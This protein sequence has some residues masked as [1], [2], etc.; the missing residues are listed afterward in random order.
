MHTTQP[1][2]SFLTLL[3]L[4]SFASVNAVLFTP[5]LPDIAKFFSIS[6]SAA[7][8]TITWFLIG[9]AIGQLIYGPLANRYGRKPA[10]FA[11][12]ALQII[13]SLI[14]VLS[15]ELHSY[16][17]LVLGRFL[18][19]LGSAVGLQM[20]FTL[21]TEYYTPKVANQKVSYLMLAFAITPGLGIALGGFLNTHFGWTSCFYACAV[22]G[23]LLLCLTL[24]FPQFQHILNYDALKLKHLLHG[25]RIQFK[26]SQLVRYALLMGCSASFVYVFAALGPFIAIDLFHLSSNAYGYAN[27][28]PS[29]GLVLGS[30]FSARLTLH[31]HLKSIIIGGIIV[32]SMGTLLM[33]ITMLN[34]TAVLFF[35]FMSMVIIYFGIAFVIGNASAVAMS[36]AIDKANGSA[37]MSFINMGLTTI[38]VLSVGLLPVVALLLPIAFIVLCSAMLLIYRNV[39]VVQ[40]ADT[41]SERNLIKPIGESTGSEIDRR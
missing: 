10:L 30:L 5:A 14:C 18:L 13:S 20:T 33:A 6:S 1:G 31:Y 29:M 3:L 38:V 23:V 7:Q 27:I 16:A 25:Y 2:L 11:G 34:H 40:T 26:N 12:I 21:V 9:Y 28:L 8:Q 41:L 39:E 22:Y 24:R 37:V 36:G 15:A 32:T 17:I 19:A 4:I 35:L